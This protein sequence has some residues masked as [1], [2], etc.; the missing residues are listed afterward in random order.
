V[1]TKLTN[2]VYLEGRLRINKNSK[3][4]AHVNWLLLTACSA[5]MSFH[6]QSVADTA[7]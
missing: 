2:S 5:I 3:Y 7:T 1:Y 6:P 4:C